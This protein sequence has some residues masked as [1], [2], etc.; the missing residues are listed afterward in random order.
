MRR[1][2]ILLLALQATS[3]SA[4]T[5]TV[6]NTNDSGAGSLRDAITAANAAAGADTIAFNVSGAG[7]DGSGL[8]TIAPDSQLPSLGDAVLVD[9]YTQPGASP[10]T[11]ATGAHQRGA[12]DRRHRAST[13][14]ARRASTSNGSRRHHPGPRRQRRASPTRSPRPARTATVRGLL[15]RHRRHGVRPPSRTLAGVYS[16]GRATTCVA[17]RC[18]ADRNLIAGNPAQN[19]CVR[20][21]CRT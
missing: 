6:T 9:G 13:S 18:P 16:N 5:F 19:I 11:N 12:Q 17:A 8:C 4:A 2:L 1:S 7:C 20:E 14:R 3:A 10:N 15:R 21:R